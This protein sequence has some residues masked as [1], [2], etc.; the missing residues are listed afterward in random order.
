LFQNGLSNK[1]VIKQWSDV[2][3]KL[4]HVAILRCGVS[5]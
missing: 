5:Y 1:F 4:N 3:P 2:P